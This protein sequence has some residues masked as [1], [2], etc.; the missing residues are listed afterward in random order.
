LPDPEL[1]D[2]TTALGRVLFT[3]DKGF[4][5][6]AAE[7]QRNGVTFVGIIYSHPIKVSV[8]QCVHD[9]EIIATAAEPDEFT[10]RLEY[11]PL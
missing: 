5:T 1:L 10:N 3:H 4:K 7:R 2:R 11:L 8:G 9:L 6:E